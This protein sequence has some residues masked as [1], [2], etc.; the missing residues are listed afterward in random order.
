LKAIG[1][2]VLCDKLYA[3]NGPLAL[4]FTRLALHAQS[5]SF[6]DAEGKMQSFEAPLPQD[7]MEARKVFGRDDLEVLDKSI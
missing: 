6:E 7:F 3:P 2:P 5:L 1:K 4:G